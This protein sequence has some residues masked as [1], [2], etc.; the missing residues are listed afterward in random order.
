MQWPTWKKNPKPVKM[1]R[2]WLCKQKHWQLWEG[3]LT[4]GAE[5]ELVAAVVT[6]LLNCKGWMAGIPPTWSYFTLKNLNIASFLCLFFQHLI[7]PW[8]LC[9]WNIFVCLLCLQ[10]ISVCTQNCILI[11]P[12]VIILFSW[13]FPESR[14]CDGSTRDLDIHTPDTYLQALGSLTDDLWFF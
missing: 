14:C 11:Q 10:G 5:G 1:L 8:V 4:S 7:I 12:L 2:K 13:D 3:L 9:V 6:P